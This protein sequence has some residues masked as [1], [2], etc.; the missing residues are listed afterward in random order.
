MFWRPNLLGR[1]RTVLDDLEG[2]FYD[3]RFRLAGPGSSARRQ[4]D[5]R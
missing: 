1:V 2:V 4:I 5:V 3:L